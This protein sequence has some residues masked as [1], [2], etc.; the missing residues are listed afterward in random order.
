MDNQTILNAVK[1]I[2]NQAI[3]VV[4]TDKQ[5]REESKA[6][7][8]SVTCKPKLQIRNIHVIFVYNKT[9][10]RYSFGLVARPGSTKRRVRHP[11]FLL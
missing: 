1:Q 11:P 5:I 2:I 10:M 7:I 8:K 6:P 3:M 9:V 4:K